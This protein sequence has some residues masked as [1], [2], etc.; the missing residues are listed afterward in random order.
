MS[1]TE[2]RRKQKERR[3]QLFIDVAQEL[4]LER[5]YEGTTIEQIVRGADFSKRTA[6][7]Y[8]ENKH[9][10]FS[11][12]VLRGLLRL[13]DR[14]EAA[15]D[16][17]LTGRQQIVRLGREYAR[18]ALDAPD[19]F[20]LLMEFE[21]RDYYYGKRGDA[22]GPYG[23]RCLEVND[24]LGEQLNAAIRRGTEDRT[25]STDLEPHQFN[26]MIWA[27]LAGVLQVA[28]W[29][30]DILPE[31]YGLD[32]MQLAEAVIERLVPETTR[33]EDQ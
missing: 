1:S 33:R 19:Y 5:G 7:L 24:A 9:D 26:L 29:R 21:R 30:R 11:A 10:L 12:V 25:F 28:V 31:S 16:T 6:Y 18:A 14:F 3:S 13:R 27:A 20:K 2:R 8:F 32:A 23:R 15:I 4:F 22:L 17:T